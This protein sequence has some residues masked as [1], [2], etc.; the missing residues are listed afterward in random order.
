MTELNE[1]LA[2]YCNAVDFSVLHKSGDVYYTSVGKSVR[3][4]DFTTSM[5]ACIKHIWPKIKGLQVVFDYFGDG[6]LMCTIVDESAYKHYSEVVKDEA[7]AF[8]LA[9]I[10]YFEV[11][12]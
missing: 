12:K 4:P 6:T 8:C 11:S 5:D 7:T 9:A 3:I 2:R 1:R 10:K